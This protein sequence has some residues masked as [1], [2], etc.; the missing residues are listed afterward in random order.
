MPTLAADYFGQKNIG[1]NYGLLFTAWG[2]AGFIVPGYLSA[3]IE[4]SRQAG[5]LAQGY[6]Q[7]FY[8]LAAIAAL[9]A[10]LALLARRP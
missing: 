7:V 2:A 10:G 9:A 4:T 1:A 5:S 6:D 8:R 3:I